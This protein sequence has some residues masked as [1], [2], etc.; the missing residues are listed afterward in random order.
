EKQEKEIELV[1]VSLQD[2]VVAFKRAYDQAA[3]RLKIQSIEE[4]E[5]TLETRIEEIR[6]IVTQ[7]PAGVPFLDIFVRRTRLEIVVTFLAILELAKQHFLRVAQKGRFGS[8][9]IMMRKEGDDEHRDRSQLDQ[10]QNNS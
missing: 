10:D 1:D 5:I 6:R 7:S 3:K 2:L 8:I 9:F 4:E